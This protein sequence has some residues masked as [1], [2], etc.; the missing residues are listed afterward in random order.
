M[1]AFLGLGYCFITA[2]S[3]FLAFFAK[4]LVLVSVDAALMAAVFA[5]RLGFDTTALSGLDG[6]GTHHQSHGKSQSSQYFD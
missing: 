4:L 3:V 1:G 5:G 2:G 6:A